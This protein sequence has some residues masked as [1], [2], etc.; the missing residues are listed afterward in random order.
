MIF[1][2]NFL[3]R[4]KV[5]ARLLKR[6]SLE[7]IIMCKERSGCCGSSKPESASKESDCSQAAKEKCG[8]LENPDK[9]C[10]KKDDK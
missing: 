3:L 5:Y 1:L 7:E 6:Y 2:E 4:Y 10:E 8:C 9:P